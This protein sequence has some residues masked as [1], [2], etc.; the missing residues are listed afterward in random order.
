M[1][2]RRAAVFTIWSRARRLK[3]TV[4]ISTIGRIPPTAAPMPMPTNPSSDRGVSRTLSGPNSSS[5]PR[6]T[7]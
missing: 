6:E 4:M 7:A 5:S 2:R 3:L 1:W